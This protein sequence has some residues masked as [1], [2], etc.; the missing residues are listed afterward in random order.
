MPH[1][2]EPVRLDGAFLADPHAACAE[3]RRRGP[4][5]R[6]VTPDGAPVRLVTGYAEVRA[7]AADPRLSLDKRHAASRGAS[8]DSLP[9][10]LDAHLLN[11]D[12]PRHTRLRAPVN[13]VLGPRQVRELR[14]R[15]QRSTDRLLD[16]LDGCRS[17]DLVADLATPLSMTV[18]CE[19][20]GVPA[21][22]RP[23]FAAWTDTLLS[24]AADAPVRSR[25]AMRAM[26]AFLTALVARRRAAPGGDLLSALIEALPDD[27]LIAMAFLLLFAGYHN[28]VGLI[29]TT[30]FAL[31]SHPDELA[32]LRAGRLTLPQV[33][34]EVLR[35]NP[36][37]LLAV[38]RFPR[39]EIEIGGTV[40]GPGER[41][42]LAWASANRDE[43][44]FPQPD[45]FRP[46]RP[47]P[48][49]HLAFGHG[50]HHCPGAALARLENEI[51]VGTLLRRFPGLALLPDPGGPH[52]RTS[53]RSRALVRLPVAL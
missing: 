19:L 4:V 1:R 13:G 21:A 12:P 49:T 6:A 40:I 24:P 42:W 36:P 20:L 33:T 30:V 38:R 27:E 45:A 14:I 23:D 29:A 48:R 5:H 44:V 26:H 35:W 9:P 17:A 51:A 22:D 31:L 46:G 41:V 52:W 3:L 32:A 47:R 10:E 28:T 25:E 53:L 2:D 43:A 50:P 7:A 34:E 18:I 15:V 39:E 37:A 8:G 16:G 11:S